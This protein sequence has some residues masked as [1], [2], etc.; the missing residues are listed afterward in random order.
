MSEAEMD[1]ALLELE[2][3]RNDRVTIQAPADET[4]ETRSEPHPSAAL[5]ADVTE[6]CLET[7]QR[8][9]AGWDSRASGRD[10]MR[11][12]ELRDRHLATVGRDAIRDEI[13][14]WS[15]EDFDLELE[16]L[17]DDDPAGSP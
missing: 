17:L 11:A 16:S 3:A 2:A 5:R 6:K 10:R 15:E 13:D 1:A 4:A 8:I 12:A 9:A 7:L 14:S